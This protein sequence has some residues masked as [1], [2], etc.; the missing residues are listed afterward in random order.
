ML[1][2]GLGAMVYL[3]LYDPISL[4]VRPLFRYLGAGVPVMLASGIVYYVLMRM[5]TAVSR[6]GGYKAGDKTT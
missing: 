2:V 4:Q 6:V 5:L 1:V 3:T